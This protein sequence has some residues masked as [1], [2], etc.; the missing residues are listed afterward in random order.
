MHN[1]NTNS[2]WANTNP[3]WANTNPLWANTNPLMCHVS[4]VIYTAP[5]PLTRHYD[6]TA[7]C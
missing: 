2:V 1:N 6:G 3:L 4:G 5:L 7:H